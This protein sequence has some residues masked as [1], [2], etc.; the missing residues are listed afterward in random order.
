MQ[1]KSALNAQRQRWRTAVATVLAAT[2]RDHDV[3]QPELAKRVGWSR[4]KL[5]KVE[6]GTRRVE[7]GDI[8]V[9]AHALGERPELVI[10][11]IL[12]WNG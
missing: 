12:G 4:D 5:A 8:T 2:R 6:A 1:S 3:T 9:V 11:R 7:L 10:R